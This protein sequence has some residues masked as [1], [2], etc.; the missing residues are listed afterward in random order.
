MTTS[1]SRCPTCGQEIRPEDASLRV[2]P[3]VARSDV[4]EGVRG[5]VRLL[6]R[7]FTMGEEDARQMLRESGYTLKSKDSKDNP[8][9][10]VLAKVQKSKDKAFHF[11]AIF[12]FWSGTTRGPVPVMEKYMETRYEKF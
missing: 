1:H 9:R 8:E 4:D 12:L 10:I 6:R 7:A 5:R 2:A 11:D 3:T